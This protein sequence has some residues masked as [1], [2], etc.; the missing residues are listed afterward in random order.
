[1]EF[2]GTMAFTAVVATLIYVTINHRLNALRCDLLATNAKIESDKERSQQ[3]ALA[4]DSALRRIEAMS[5]RQNVLEISIDEVKARL[6][7]EPKRVLSTKDKKSL[8]ISLLE[9]STTIEEM[10]NTTG[11][12]RKGV[13]RYMRKFL[14]DGVAECLKTTMPN[15]WRLKNK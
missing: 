12:S 5:A 14:D 11:L 3:N 10:M 1:M 7:K 9:K 8:L 13:S 6:V 2:F 15:V 4:T